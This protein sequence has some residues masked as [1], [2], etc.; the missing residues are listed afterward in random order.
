MLPRIAFCGNSAFKRGT[1]EFG[2]FFTLFWSE[3]S[4]H[5]FGLIQAIVAEQFHAFLMGD[6]SVQKI[7]VCFSDKFQ[8]FDAKGVNRGRLLGAK[9]QF[10]LNLG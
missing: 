3:D 7:L 9:L 2:E 8:A 1:G 10:A 6:C 4:L 5:G